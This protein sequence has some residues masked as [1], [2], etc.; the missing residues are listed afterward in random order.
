MSSFIVQIVPDWDSDDAN[1][2]MEA[3]V[4]FTG[5]LADEYQQNIFQLEAIV[6]KT[7]CNTQ[8]PHSI[9]DNMGLYWEHIWVDGGIGRCARSDEGGKVVL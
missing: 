4:A 1:M 2:I 6:N 7:I 9:A 3:V 5:K 8:T